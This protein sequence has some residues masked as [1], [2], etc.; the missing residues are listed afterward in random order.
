MTDHAKRG[1]SN[2]L[3]GASSERELVGKLKEAGW[4][5][6]ERTSNGR[7]QAKGDIANG[8]KHAVIEVRNKQ[9]YSIHA[10]L[11]A[12]S[13]LCDGPEFPVLFTRKRGGQWTAHLPA[14]ELLSLLGMRENTAEWDS[15][16]EKVTKPRTSRRRL[17][18]GDVMAD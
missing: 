12:V 13:A 3:K 7:R 2:R 10:E 8:P 14:D 15:F 18:I 11:Q 1:K 9:T 5:Y 17:S 4:P 16:V 6:A